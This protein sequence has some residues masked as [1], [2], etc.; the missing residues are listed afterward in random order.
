MK[1]LS[2]ERAW[3]ERQLISIHTIW[4]SVKSVTSQ[5]HRGAKAARSL[6]APTQ[7]THLPVICLKEDVEPTLKSCQRL[8]RTKRR[9]DPRGK[10][11]TRDR[12]QEGLA[13][14]RIPTRIRQRSKAR[15]HSTLLRSST[16]VLK[17][18]SRWGNRLL[19]C[20]RQ[21]SERRRSMTTRLNLNLMF[22]SPTRK[23]HP[24]KSVRP[25]KWARKS[26]VRSKK[27]STSCSSFVAPCTQPRTIRKTRF[28]NCLS[29]AYSP[30]LKWIPSH[31]AL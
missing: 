7:K 28:S 3:L 1:R 20:R 8:K 12:N 11:P 16:L 15:P 23:R 27:W 5:T 21:R 24:T 31:L 14:I 19:T 10:L 22:C 4:M 17:T 18:V 26:W 13:V 2:A 25:V 29:S 30:R 9:R 6:S